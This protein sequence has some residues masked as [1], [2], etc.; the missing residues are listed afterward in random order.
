[1]YAR[2]NAYTCRPG[3][4]DEVLRRVE[5][6]QVPI[7]RAQPGFLS[8][9]FVR[10]GPDTGLSISRWASTAD[11]ERSG[12]PSGAWVRETVADTIVDSH[13]HSGEVVITTAG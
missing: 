7:L 10:T 8:Y 4:L 5:A 9:E 1:M 6:E 2:V 13:T 3:A 11:A 12:G